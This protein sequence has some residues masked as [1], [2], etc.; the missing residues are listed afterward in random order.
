MRA[1]GGVDEGEWQTTLVVRQRTGGGRLQERVRWIARRRREMR[2]MLLLESK[3]MAACTARGE[4]SAVV[5]EG[6]GTGSL[7]EGGQ[8]RLGLG[9]DTGRT[10]KLALGVA[11]SMSMSVSALAVAQPSPQSVST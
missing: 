9:T 4:L 7:S 10:V 3:E 8:A 1:E 2:L 11:M 6:D 5:G